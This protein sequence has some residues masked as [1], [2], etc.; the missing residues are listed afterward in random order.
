M[1]TIKIPYWEVAVK[2]RILRWTTVLMIGSISVSA[3]NAK[4][5][6]TRI[7]ILDLD[8][9]EKD[10][11][12]ARTAQDSLASYIEDIGAY[13]IVD[14]MNME[15]FYR[16]LKQNFPRSCRDPRCVAGIGSSIQLDRMLYGS[17]DVNENVYAVRLTLLDVLSRRVIE[18][19]R[20]ES[21]P[22]VGLSELMK[23]ATMKLHGQED[24]YLNGRTHTY[25]GPEVHNV[26]ELLIAAPL[27]LGAGVLVAVVNGSLTGKDENA[28]TVVSDY[29]DMR[30]ERERLLGINPGADIMPLFARPGA[31]ANSYMA[32]SDDA[33]GVFYNP[34][35]MSWTPGAEAMLAYQNR[36]GMNNFAASYVNKATREIGFG[37][38]FLYNG[39]TEGLLTEMYFVSAV[40][41]KF[42]EL[43]SF[44]RPFSLGAALKVKSTKTGQAGTVSASTGSAFGYGLDW[45]ILW[46]LTEQIRGALV[47]KNAPS[48]YKWHNTA[49]DTSYGE[50]V[51]PNLYMGGVFQANYS[52]FLI[53]DMSIPINPEQEWVFSGGIERTILRVIDLRLGI[54]KQSFHETPWKFAGGFGLDLDTRNVLGRRLKLDGSYEYNTLTVFAH[55]LNF[56]LKFGF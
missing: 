55:V 33:Y 38:G 26:R 8:V 30:S 5:I 41:Y 15:K 39:D 31:L 56:S 29:S 18:H 32:A 49:T 16:E 47:M 53:F 10:K 13:E 37:Q 42:N 44:L 4:A 11:K 28:N 52:T 9:A 22:G 24:E 19:V 34:A 36:F 17:L 3:Q 21:E 14:Q 6:E 45:G 46:E 27:C 43:I 7:G 25:Y 54:R 40:S 1:R 2:A 51:P 23:V 20:I 35:G 50:G 12:T 48:G